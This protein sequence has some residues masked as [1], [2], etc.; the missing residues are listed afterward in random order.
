MEISCLKKFKTQAMLVSVMILLI[1][2]NPPTIEKPVYSCVTSRQFQL[3]KCGMR[4]LDYKKGHEVVGE[5]IDPTQ[6]ETKPLQ[7]CPDLV[8]YSL[9]DHLTVIKPKLKEIADYYTDH[10]NSRSVE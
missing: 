10:F 7:E 3:C 6:L 5:W 8:G 2:C 4:S 1:G 9:E